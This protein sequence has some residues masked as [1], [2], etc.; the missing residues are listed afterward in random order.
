MTRHRRF[1]S[2]CLPLLA[3]GVALL[4]VVVGVP[5]AG[6]A[7]RR[8][9]GSVPKSVERFVARGY[10]GTFSRPPTSGPKAAKDKSVWVISCGQVAASCSTPADAAMKAGK[11]AGWS[12]HLYDAQLNPANYTVGI[13]EAIADGAN[14]IVTI[15][16]DCDLAKAPL[17]QAEAAGIKTVPIVGFDCNTPIDKT[18]TPE[19]STSILFNGEPTAAKGIQEM[20]EFKGAWL[21]TKEHG[22][23]DVIS[24]QEPGFLVSANETKGL[25]DEMAKCSTCSLVDVTLAPSTLEGSG[26]EQKLLAALEKYPNVNGVVMGNDSYFQQFGNSALNS[27]GRKAVLSIGSTCL[28]TNVAE[29]RSGG[30]EDACVGYS[31]V[32]EG[33]AAID[34]LNRQFAKPGSA[35]VDE[36]I[37]YQIVTKRHN[38]PASGPWKVSVDFEADYLKVW[39]GK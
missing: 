34:E 8:S 22:H 20:D 17:Q 36:G 11:A 3:A 10:K 32:W 24:V 23:A 6:A 5:S 21:I 30:P 9:E 7:G 1:A 28:P 2:L 16:V 29:I 31:T 12:M 37:G 27:A 39:R 38:M 25:D 19:Y 13:D 4:L 35:P 15:A 33:W 14:G 26:A 18:G